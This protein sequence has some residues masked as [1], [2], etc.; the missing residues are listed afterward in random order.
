[1]SW[2]DVTKLD[3]AGQYSDSDEIFKSLNE[4]IIE[5]LDNSVE[6]NR[7][8]YKYSVPIDICL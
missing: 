8:L 5:M 1:M 7:K 4:Y 2:I 6:F 3:L